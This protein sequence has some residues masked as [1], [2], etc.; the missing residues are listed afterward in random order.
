MH[1]TIIHLEMQVIN[2]HDWPDRSLSYL[3]RSFDQLEHGKAYQTS[4]PVIQIGILDFTLFPE[5]PEFYAT[6]QLLNVNN[7]T[8]YSDKLRLSMLDLTQIKLATE[9][10]RLYQID[11][12][13]ALFKATTWEDLKMLA[14][15][16]S[17]IAEASATVYQLS[18][19]EKIRL[20][21]EAREDYYHR[22][23]G[24]QYEMDMQK[25]RIQEQDAEIE[26]LTAMNHSLLAEKAAWTAEREQLLAQINATQRSEKKE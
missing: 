24:I 3:C 16:N 2:Q 10:D 19:D 22:Q 5:H 23:A 14:E 7:Y 20:Q 18:Q 26:T 12:W 1:N 8:K 17:Y 13:A 9:K 4:K 15:N 25:S 11:Y 21:C 6:Y